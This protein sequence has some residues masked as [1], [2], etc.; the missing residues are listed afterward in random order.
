MFKN[1][2]LDNFMKRKLLKN[3]LEEKSLS[4]QLSSFGIVVSNDDPLNINRIKVRIP[5]IDDHFFKDEE[6]SK[7][8]DN[9]PWCLP[10]N[11]NFIST[12]E[13]NSI[14]LVN[15]FNLK[16]TDVGRVYLD[17]LSDL[18]SEQILSI[19][20]STEED[21]T[22][23]NWDN[24]EKAT[25]Y[26]IPNKPKNPKELSQDN[27]VKYEV[28]VRGKGNNFFK[29]TKDSFELYQNKDKEES[30]I[31]VNKNI[32]IESSNEMGLLSKKG[33]T[34]Y[35]P[36]FHKPLYD[37]IK[38]QNA[39]IKQIIIVMNTIPSIDTRTGTPS[40]PSPSARKLVPKLSSLYSSFAKLKIDGNGHSKY[41]WVN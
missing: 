17:C 36:V 31:I 21:K 3:T 20:R 12:P 40:T 22:Y 18:N 39:L 32:V 27:K 15:Y 7:G 29:F 1:G 19:S 14:V 2:D 10:Q 30:K 28:G 4:E 38:E 5:K 9:L 23:G 33:G 8:I 13:V 11:R 26:K 25:N 37:F 34:E 24:A 35:H 16:L 41:I 6:D